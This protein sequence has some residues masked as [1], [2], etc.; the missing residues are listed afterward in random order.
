MATIKFRVKGTRNPSPIYLQYRDG[1]NNIWLKTGKTID[2][3]EWSQKTHRPLIF[4][5]KELHSL[6]SR[7]ESL[8]KD[9]KDASNETDPKEVDKEWLQKRIAI[10]N[11]ELVDENTSSDLLVDAV[12]YIIE[13]ASIRNNSKGTLGLSKSRIN[14]Y[15][16]LKRILLEYQGKRKFRIRDVDIKFGK[17]FLDWML[18]KRKY[19][20]SY[21][22]KKIDDLKAVCS[23]AEVNGHHVSLQLKKIKGGKPKPEFIIYLNPEELKKIEETALNIETLKNVRKWLLLGCNLGQRGQDLLNLTKEN[24]VTRHGLEVIEL[25]QQKTGKQVT[26]PVLPVTKEIL[27]EGLPHKISLQKFNEKL[28]VLCEKAGITEKIPGYKIEMIDRNGNVIP[29]EK[30][31]KRKLKG[32]KR[33]IKSSYPKWQLISSH[34]CRRSFATKT[35]G[36]LPTPLIMQITAHSTEKMLLNYIGKSSMDFAQVI[37]DFYAKEAKKD[38]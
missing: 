1:K 38:V 30:N 23:D 29:K 12:D 20:E 7:L 18:N 10:F 15:K 6:N 28:K 33:K 31:G 5:R 27:Q 2:P 9:I 19:S 16:N 34:V 11:N 37:A 13:T 14:S 21:A 35:Y 26:I 25:K 24:F 3:T 36:N 17:D 32:E 8:A 4:R 22:R